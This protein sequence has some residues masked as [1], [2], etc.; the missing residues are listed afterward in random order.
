MVLSFRNLHLLHTGTIDCEP[1][2]LLH[3]QTFNYLIL[4][5]AMLGLCGFVGG[6]PFSSSILGLND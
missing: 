1:F 2:R 4:S 3:S 5:F 6:G